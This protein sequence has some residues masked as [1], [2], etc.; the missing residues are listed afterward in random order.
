MFQDPFL[1]PF[2]P[3]QR[4]FWEGEN[5]PGWIEPLRRIYDCELVYLSSGS[6][7]LEIAGRHHR[8][9]AGEIII[10][11]PASWHESW[12]GAGEAA[13]RH[14][15]HFDWT[16]EKSRHRPPLCSVYGEPFDEE[17]VHRVPTAI[18]ADLPLVAAVREHPGLQGVVELMLKLLREQNSM[19]DHLL[20]A[21]LRQLTAKETHAPSQAMTD[22]RRRALCALKQFIDTRYAEP[23]GYPEFQR[24]TRLSASH[25]CRA[26]THWLGRTPTAYLNDLRLQR[27]R[28]LLLQSTMSVKEVATAVG[29]LDTNYFARSFR[30]KFG[31]S[32]SGAA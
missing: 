2:L 20:W 18:A 22:R 31:T 5:I 8:L 16:P 15:I 17:Q 7:T 19:A 4:F 1:N 32:P 28:R 12:T 26:F 29:I 25:L 21:V 3:V 13:T 10:V 11:P 30:R 24:L 14:C 9:K 23:I 27:A 6:F